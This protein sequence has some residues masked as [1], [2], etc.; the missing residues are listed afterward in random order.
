M[1]KIIR[2]IGRVLRKLFDGIG[3]KYE[4]DPNAVLPPRHAICRT[5]LIDGHFNEAI[6]GPP[7]LAHEKTIIVHPSLTAIPSK[8]ITNATEMKR[9]S[10]DD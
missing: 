3:K 6:Q 4:P 8:A 7:H 2:I 5:K 9:G 1:K 10:L